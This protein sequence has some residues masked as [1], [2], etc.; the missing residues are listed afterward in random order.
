MSAYEYVR[1]SRRNEWL[2]DQKFSF[3]FSALSRCSPKFSLCSLNSVLL[4]YSK[5]K[6]FFVFAVRLA[7]A[8]VRQESS[9]AVPCA[10]LRYV[11]EDDDRTTQPHNRN[12][13]RTYNN[14][15]NKQQQQQQH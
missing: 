10:V 12:I 6:M 8:L 9:L 7:R 3:F 13:I 5:G 4:S 2:L 15:Y 1:S 11:Y 14:Y